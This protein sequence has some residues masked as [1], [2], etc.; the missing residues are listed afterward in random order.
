MDANTLSSAILDALETRLAVVDADGRILTV[1]AAWA[2]AA[3]ASGDPDLRYTG[4]GVNYLAVLRQAAEDEPAA[5]AA[6]VGLQA[7][8]SG[9]RQR[10]SQ[11][12]P[13]PLPSGEVRWF[14]LRVTPLAG[15][16]G[17]VVVAH[18]D[19]SRQRL[20]EVRLAHHF[21]L[22]A[23]VGDAVIATDD[24]W[25][26]TAFN[27]AAEALYGW[28]AAE[29][30]GRRLADAVGA[31]LPADQQAALLAAL[32]TTG[33]H[34]Q[35]LRH[36]HRDG[37]PIE[38]DVVVLALRD[39]AGRLVGFLNVNHDLTAR[40]Q[41]EVALAQREADLRAIFD[42]SQQ[43]F[44]LLDPAGQ[45]RARNAAA[46]ARL[47]RLVGQVVPNGSSLRASLPPEERAGF[48]H[49]F[50]LA[51][52]GQHLTVGKGL[53]RPGG[54]GEWY[55]LTYGPVRDEAGQTLGVCL[56]ITDITDRQRA[57]AALRESQQR[58]ELA[59][60]GADVGLWD[61]DFARGAL[62]VDERWAA[63]LGYSLDEIEPSLAFLRTLMHPE[64]WPRLQQALADQARGHTP[65]LDV[66]LRLRAP[67]GRWRWI[68]SR[69]R[70]LERT[71]A[72]QPLRAVGTHLDLTE[73]KARE[74]ELEAIVAI[75]AALRVTHSR[76]AMVPAILRETQALLGVTEVGLLG[77]DPASADAV[78]EA[79]GG[80][81]AA[82]VGRRLVL[83][84]EV[85]GQ[86]LHNGRAYLCSDVAADSLAAQLGPAA[87]LQSLAAVP[88]TAAGEGVGVLAAG[89]HGHLP[90]EAVR[91]L[92]VVADIAASAL[93]RAALYEQAQY[94]AEQ[95]TVVSTA[96]Q[97]LAETL[98][99]DRIHERLYGL[100]LR[101][102]PD[103]EAV[104]VA[105]YD[106]EQQRLLTVY[107]REGG[108]RVDVAQRPPLPLEPHGP[109]NEAILTRRP[110][111]VND[112]P[113]RLRL[114]QPAHGLA[115]PQM[116][117]RSAL[118][119]PLMARGQVVGVVQVQSL[120]LDRYHPLDAELLTV[121]GNTAALA[122]ENARLF[123][124]ARRHLGQTQALH[125]IDVAISGSVDL[126]VILEVALTQVLVQLRVDAALVRLLDAHTQLLT[127][128]ASRG[129]RNS[130]VCQARVRVGTALAG[131]V[132]LECRRLVVPDLAA[133][134]DA[135]LSPEFLSAEGFRAYVG[136][137]L[138]AKGQVLGVLEVFQREP[139]ALDT[140]WLEFLDALA[141]QVAIAVDNAGLFT[142]LRR[143]YQELSLAYDA[144]IEG[145]SR[146]LDIRDK[147]TEGH[148]RR[149]ADLAVH[150]ARAL[151]LS[152]ADIVH[153][154][155][156]A[157]LHD[158]G[159]LGV[160]D[161]ILLKPG[162]LTE[163]EWAIMRRHPALA[164]EL[165]APITYLQPALDIPYAHHEK[166]DGS[167]YPRGL[168]GDAIP[169]AARLF[170]IVDVW[171]A[172]RSDR[173]YRPA[174]P[175]ERVLAHLR[176]QAGTH[177]DPRV[178]DVFLGLLANGAG[179]GP[180]GALVHWES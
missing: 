15:V 133:Y 45:I 146:A 177:F 18:D 50:A 121:V 167:G 96:G 73:R 154:R 41:A 102:L 24:H 141:G 55:E 139:L 21:H 76:A 162:P 82:A 84:E 131:A 80:A 34:Q 129:F 106:P 178:V 104:H 148:T 91:R 113:A 83:S 60:R 68:L 70:V 117:P 126:R 12:Y 100:I 98:D 17:R 142:E 42:S 2:E 152:P 92:R 116:R 31:E 11:D 78:V 149:V 71:P 179:C 123:T 13:C 49:H 173:P 36:R 59:L 151:G 140:D 143:S 107:A 175:V 166:W 22:L 75:S 93:H 122:L 134:P 62:R 7:V 118:Y 77:R 79:A 105:R 119:V 63:M 66:E 72:G 94:R 115:D 46:D 19:V 138:V 6:L 69:G 130:A 95:L 26:I 125:A 44:V 3:R 101:L 54:A 120:P 48:D 103:S 30:V 145:W 127:P 85:L 136:A 176:A 40:R 110:V 158:I 112:L 10:Y 150:L 16:A 35:S 153:I 37:A 128:A 137:P 111:I 160:P 43:A 174:W 97:V 33:R 65:L 164:Y 132:A 156:G 57:E 87:A 171:D 28:P 32:Q 135:E 58:L 61:A 180:A 25:R 157:L 155:R 169:L 47:R 20:D 64:D 89:W 23:T 4:P 124:E 163:A 99:V 144:T 5:L 53:M 90:D 170:A 161:A 86:V 1:N 74:R 52:S 88:L 147:E 168:K 114:L 9:E 29:V 38:V 51:L 159:K 27:P 108:Q 8:I 56:T 67:D 39:D 81:W 172:L 14:H 109:Q 165:L